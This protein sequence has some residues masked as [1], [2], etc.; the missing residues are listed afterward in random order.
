M[1]TKAS[2]GRTA[3]HRGRY[4]RLRWLSMSAG[5][6]LVLLAGGGAS[7]ALGLIAPG[8][9]A[10]PK[11]PSVIDRGEVWPARPAVVTLSWRGE[12]D[13][14]RGQQPCVSPPVDTPAVQL[15]TPD[16]VA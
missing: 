2:N 10:T 15:A 8:A 6:G 16:A 11:H 13:I 4:H 14:S 9:S 5:L 3:S 12:N 1:F 7:A